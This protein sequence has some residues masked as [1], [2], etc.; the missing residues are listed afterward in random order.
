MKIVHVVDSMEVGGAEVLVS[1]MCRMQRDQGHDPHVLAVAALGVLGEQMLTE[2]FEVTASVGRH[3]VDSAVRF[4]KIFRKLK[5]DVVHLHNPTPTMYAGPAARMAGVPAIVST[6]HSLVA[7]PHNPIMER[8]YRIAARF[9][10]WVVGICDATAENLRQIE[11]A[12]P[13]KII[14][15]YNGALSIPSVPLERRVE[16]VGFTL[17]YV[18]RLHPIKNHPMML[19]A[20]HEARK[21]APE[22][23]LWMVGDGSERASLEALASD[24]KITQYVKFWGQ[25]VDVAPFYLSADAFMMSSVSE[26]LPISLLQAFS[27]GLPA[28]VTNVGGMAEVVQ[29]AG[30]GEIVPLSDV[31]T[32]ALAID[33]IA[34]NATIREQYSRAGK[35]AFQK[36]FTLEKMVISYGELYRNTAF[37][38]RSKKSR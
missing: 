17:L 33:R 37:M 8:K 19:R 4:F 22:L 3:L 10:D 34:T 23:R 18:G 30:A 2:G 1:Q 14:R 29:L 24:L 9:C 21:M 36:Y 35:Q 11:S 26:G 5:P 28:I 27:V 6:R 7:A 16:T 13:A 38:K 12:K 31:D 25:Q 20:F 15:V 32:M